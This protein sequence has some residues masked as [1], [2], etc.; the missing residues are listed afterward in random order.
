[1]DLF[2][3]IDFFIFYHFYIE[4]RFYAS[5]LQSRIISILSPIQDGPFQGYSR[6][7]RG[8]EGGQKTPSLKCL[9]HISQ[10]W[11]FAQL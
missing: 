10:W 8:E 4:L 3:H 7:G 5:T 11:N 6:M 2:F 1:M 9:T